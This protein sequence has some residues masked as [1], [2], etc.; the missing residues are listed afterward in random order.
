MSE[1]HYYNEINEFAADWLLNLIADGLIPAGEVDTRSIEDVH[2]SDLQG[3]VQCHFFAGIGGWPLALRRAGWPSDR[4]VWTGSCPC[5][6]FSSAGE[7]AGFADERHLWPHFYHL[8]SAHRDWCRQQ[9]R[10]APILLGEQVASKD[11]DP[12][13]DLVC[14]DL[15]ALGDAFAAIPF[16]SASIG[17][18]HIRDRNYWVGYPDSG[19]GGKG[20]ANVRGRVAG[21][22]A[23]SR[24]G[25][26]GAGMPGG[27]GHADHARLEGYAGDGGAAGRQGS[28]RPV[29]EAGVS[30]RLA[31]ADG[32]LEGSA[33]ISS[34]AGDAGGMREIGGLADADGRH[35]GA[36][37]QQ[38]SGEQRQQPQ[39]GGCGVV[40][41]GRLGYADG[42]RRQSIA[43]ESCRDGARVESPRGIPVESGEA[44]GHAE[45]P[46]PINGMWRDADWL[47]CR[48]AKWRP[49]EAGTFPLADGLP[50]GVGSSG[51]E[52]ARLA[53]LAGL[54]NASLARAKAYRVG[55]LR[56]YGNAINPEQAA[57]FIRVVM[58][59]A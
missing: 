1:P 53:G 22:D 56:G 57:E 12:W 26:G 44:S 8:I 48:D 10:G 33:G 14:A 34:R 45:Q 36:E 3:F 23:Q 41:L 13:I 50:R 7:G 9:K 40:G 51:A 47:Y 38:R 43:N 28:E 25:S 32:K 4:P 11:A 42:S 52:L 35:A 27:M 30:V 39:D 21:S 15:E 58:E 6:P 20:R 29:T 37:R 2:P 24:T 5:Q 55:A 18:P 16:P 46:G 17:A 54:D 19:T 59:A 31:D 49:V